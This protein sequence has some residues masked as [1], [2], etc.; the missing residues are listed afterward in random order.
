MGYSLRMFGKMWCDASG[1]NLAMAGDALVLRSTTNDAAAWGPVVPASI[2][3]ESTQPTHASHISSR[4][5]CIY[6][7]VST[8]QKQ[9]WFSSLNCWWALVSE[10]FFKECLSL[11][12]EATTSPFFLSLWL[13][14]DCW[15]S[16]S[17]CSSMWSY[18]SPLL[19]PDLSILVGCI[20]LQWLNPGLQRLTRQARLKGIGCSQETTGKRDRAMEV[21]TNPTIVGFVWK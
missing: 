10:F 7:L 4:Q 3:A 21:V 6:T 20:G 12:I 1:E 13:R 19:G 18:S 16:D 11:K 14:H 8:D 15:S 9:F 2:R 17:L 5:K